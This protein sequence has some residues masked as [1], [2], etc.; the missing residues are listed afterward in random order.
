MI[1]KNLNSGVVSNCFANCTIEGRTSSGGLVGENEGTINTSYAKGSLTPS[2]ESS[3]FGGLVGRNTSYIDQC[4]SNVYIDSDISEITGGGFVGSNTSTGNITNSYFRGTIETSDD[5]DDETIASGFV[6]ENEGTI[7]NCYAQGTISGGS[8][9]GFCISNTG[10]ITNSFWD[11]TSF[12]SIGSQGGTART[13]AQMQ[14]ESTF[15][16]AGWHFTCQIWGI[17]THDNGKYPFLLWQEDYEFPA[18]DCNYW[19]GTPEQTGVKVE[20]VKRGTNR[21]K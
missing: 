3:V 13:T 2:F 11:E 17:N 6:W 20:L 16:N 9:A 10:T 15:T 14:T 5:P 4:Y 18:S 7:T 8:I 12:G 21:R 19:T 1:G